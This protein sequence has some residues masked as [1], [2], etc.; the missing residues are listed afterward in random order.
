MNT[1]RFLWLKTTVV[2]ALLLTAIQ[3]QALVTPYLIALSNGLAQYSQVLDAMAPTTPAVR[4]EAR[5]LQRALRD[6]SRP[7]SSLATDYRRFLTAALH[8]GNYAFTDPN[9]S[10]GGSNV[11]Q[12]FMM[13]AGAEIGGTAA[14]IAALNDFVRTKRSAGRHLAQAQALLGQQATEP[15]PKIGLLRGTQVFSRI[16]QAQRL[17]AFGESHQ[18]F[19]ASSVV[20]GTLDHTERNSSGQLVFNGDGTGTE[21]VNGMTENFTYT[22]TRTALNKATLV[23]DYGPEGVTTVKLYFRSTGGGRFTA[24]HLKDGAANRDAG[25]FTLAF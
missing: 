16:V 19:A 2:A 24:R 10:V 15:D 25:T 13:D 6:L 14:R 11:F 7:S 12:A 22:Y 17:T 1:A 18:G 8:M 21:T 23:L 5:A 3:S 9:L 20:G 4:P